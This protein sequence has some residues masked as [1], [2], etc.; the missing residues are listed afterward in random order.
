[1]LRTGK[2]DRDFGLSFQQAEQPCA[3]YD[4]DFELGM[5]VGERSYARRQEDVAKPIGCADANRPGYRLYLVAR[6]RLGDNVGALDRLGPRKKPF[7]GGG[8]SV[9]GVAL[10]EETAVHLVLKHV[11]VARHRRVFGAELCRCGRKRPRPRDRQKISKVVPILTWLPVCHRLLPLIK[12]HQ[13][14]ICG[15]SLH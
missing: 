7:A 2:A 1:M 14:G 12:A 15:R 3:W 13:L 11:N 9:A 4:L 8:Q 6:G 10:V 5:P